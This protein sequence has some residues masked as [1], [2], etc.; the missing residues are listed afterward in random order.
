MSS[1]EWNRSQH[2]SGNQNAQLLNRDK[3]SQRTTVG[4]GTG[5][6]GDKIKR[7]VTREGGV[8]QY[9]AEG[10]PFAESKNGKPV[11][12]V[13]PSIE[14][15][16]KT[17]AGQV[18][19]YLTTD[20]PELAGK[21]SDEIIESDPESPT[22]YWLSGF[23]K[24]QSG[25]REGAIEV[26]ERGLKVV[27]EDEGLKTLEKL[28]TRKASDMAQ[29]EIDRRRNALLGNL[30]KE[31]S[32]AAGPSFFADERAFN[33]RGP[34]AS[35]GEFKMAGMVHPGMF[36]GADAGAAAP[37][38]RV[39]DARQLSA[40]KGGLS[41]MKVGD[42]KVAVSHFTEAIRRGPSNAAGYRFR[43]MAFERAGAHE[44]AV[45]DANRAL[46]LDANDHWAFLV[47]AKALT[48]LKQYEAAEV[49][50]EGALALKPQSADI[51]ATRA[52]R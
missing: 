12:T 33:T 30:R 28:F 5:I 29:K 9:N 38:G 11:L 45:E 1:S 35:D 22:G 26:V 37:A 21:I 24:N 52:K 15:K 6:A 51:Y 18:Q 50:L 13:A 4:N 40:I 27:P 16:Y 42:A 31:D 2:T 23:V 41:A 43:A 14:P 48:A 47:R 39:P 25:D 46:A 17:Q 34:K 3:T 19:Y 7:T 44:R 10:G 8:T 36:R 32:D 20:E 49:D